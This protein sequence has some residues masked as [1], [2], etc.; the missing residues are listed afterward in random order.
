MF[1]TLTVVYASTL[2]VSSLKDSE[3]VLGGLTTPMVRAVDPLPMINVGFQ[4]LQF[5]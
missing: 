4:A 2:I 1:G 5:G 3:V